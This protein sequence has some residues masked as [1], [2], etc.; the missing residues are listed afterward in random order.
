MI[1][2]EQ[3]QE[4]DSTVEKYNIESWNGYNMNPSQII[5][6]AVQDR[7]SVLDVLTKLFNENKKEGNLGYLHL[8]I[9]MLSITNQIEYL[10]SKL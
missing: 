6:C 8:Y 10:K 3:K 5:K 1:T 7:Q 9:E 4:A 2:E